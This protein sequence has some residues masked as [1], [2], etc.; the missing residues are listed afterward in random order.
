MIYILEGERLQTL[1]ES[2]FHRVVLAL[3]TLQTFQE[4]RSCNQVQI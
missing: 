4:L 1:C 3:F 2:E